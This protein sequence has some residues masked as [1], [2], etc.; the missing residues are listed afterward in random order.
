MWVGR[1]RSGRPRAS[2][3][4]RRASRARTTAGSSAASGRARPSCA[5]SRGPVAPGL[6]ARGARDRV[7]LEH[8]VERAE[9]ERRPRRRGPGRAPASTPPTTLVPPPY[10]IDGDAAR[11]RT[12]PAR[13]RRRASSRG[14]RDDV[15]RVR[16]APAEAA[17]DVA[18]G[19]AV[20]VRRRARGRRRR[21]SRPAPAGRA[22]RGAG[23]VDR[24]ERARRL[25][26]REPK[27]SCAASPARRGAISAGVGCSSSKPQPQCLRACARARVYGAG[28]RRMRCATRDL[29]CP[30]ARHPRPRALAAPEQVGTRAGA[31]TPSS[32]RPSTR[33]PPTRAIAELRT[34]A[35]PA[36][37]ASPRG[38]PA[39]SADDGGLEL[40]LQPMRWA[41]RL[42]ATTPAASLAALCVRATP[43]AAGWPG[44]ARRGSRPGPAAG[45]SAPA[46]RSRSARTR[47]RRSRASCTRSGRSRPS[48]LAV[49]ALVALPN[50]LVMLVGQA[51]L[52][53]GRRGRRRDH[54]HDEHAWWPRRLDAWPEEADPA[55]R[56]MARCCA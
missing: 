2:R 15:G 39:S 55:L 18:V 16:E 29:R 1:S 48:A 43:T 27:P 25:D 3:S 52:A 26:L 56:R 6:D 5:S 13:A 21:R 37:T 11:R 31:R 22:T 24:V 49:E 23:S 8:A 54:E 40:E 36:T 35:R 34:A 53:R 19:L 7:D 42:V 30:R 20:R 28:A 45:R 47:P 50:R 51:W 44:A 17:H 33:A 32:R 14:P 9:V 4:S 38:S 46:A 10:G 12:T 41:L